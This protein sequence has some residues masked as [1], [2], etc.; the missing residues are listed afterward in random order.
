MSSIARS[1]VGRARAPLPSLVLIFAAWLVPALL[2]GFDT[3][4]QSRLEGHAP[5]WHW[6]SFNSVDWLLYAA[7]T[8]FVFRA[9]RRLPL[10]LPNLARHIVVHIA[11][12]LGMCVAWAGLGTI[13]RLAIFP[14]PPDLTGLKVLREF[15]AWIFTTLPFGVGVYFALVG[16]EHS[17]FYFAQARE[18]QTQAARL[19]AQLAQAR[20]SALQH[21]TQSALSLQ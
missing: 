18:R 11:G 9:G 10:Q 21:A 19:A 7:L 2:S 12:A 13:L 20:L 8:P 17:L 16:I 6:V 14:V 3:F 15:V 4:M 1:P 5:D